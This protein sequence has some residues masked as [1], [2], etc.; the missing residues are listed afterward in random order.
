MIWFAYHGEK[1]IALFVMIP[2]INQILRKLNGKM[3]L[4]GIA[5]FLW[6]KHRKIMTRTRIFIMGIDP[7]YQ[8]SGVESAIFWHQEQ[9]MKK[10]PQYTEVELSWAGDFNPKII[11]VYEATGAKRAKTHYT[12]RYLFDGEKPFVRAPIIGPESLNEKVKTITGKN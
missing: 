11:A 12:M 8:R 1:P 7:K 4:W 6:Y 9:K 2:D 10:K 5:K 3:N